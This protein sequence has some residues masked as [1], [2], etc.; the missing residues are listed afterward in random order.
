MTNENKDCYNCVFRAKL[1]GDAHSRCNNQ[2]DKEE[3][4][5][6]NKMITITWNEW[7]SRFPHNFDPHWIRKCKKHQIIE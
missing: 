6:K 7:S 1:I 2:W 4:N 3:L 5:G